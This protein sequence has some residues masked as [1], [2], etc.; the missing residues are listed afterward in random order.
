MCEC[1]LS[2]A[3]RKARFEEGVEELELVGHVLDLDVGLA[4]VEH[5]Q[6]GG[7]LR[8]C[9]SEVVLDL[10]VAPGRGVSKV[11]VVQQVQQRADELR[12][13]IV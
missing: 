6:L 5:R 12:H 2:D 4:P 7:V 3:R 9:L 10:R 13:Q 1:V 11:E 8:F